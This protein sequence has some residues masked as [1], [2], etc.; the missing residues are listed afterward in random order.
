[1]RLYYLRHPERMKATSRKSKQK[2]RETVRLS[3]ERWRER[4][5]ESVRL[6]S[7]KWRTNNRQKVRDMNRRWASNNQGYTRIKVLMQNAIRLMIRSSGNKK[8]LRSREYIGCSA[9]F[10]R[11]WLEAQFHDGMTWDNYGTVWVVD[12]IVPL[13][14]WDVGN[15][16]QHLYEAS[17]YSNLQPMLTC[18]NLIK[19]ARFAG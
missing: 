19:G 13:K 12:H 7:L 11:G 14:W 1:M 3:N 5:R 17:H 15:F 9:S 18:D 16:P 6:Q 2:N 8:E 4:N 10:L